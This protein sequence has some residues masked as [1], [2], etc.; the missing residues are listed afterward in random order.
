[1]HICPV[2]RDKHNNPRYLLNMKKITFILIA[3]ITGTTFA[4]DNAS[5]AVNAEIV[6]PITVSTTVPLEFGR[7][8][9]PSSATNVVVNTTAGGTRP[10]VAGVTLAGGAAATAASFNITAENT[11]TYDITVA[12][13]DLTPNTGA[14]ATMS[15][16]L[17]PDAT[18][19]TGT[20][21]A[22]TLFVGG[23]LVVNSGQLSDSYTGSAKVTVNYN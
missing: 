5:A 22:Q 12:A 10:D 2:N 21:S 7:I 17:Q 8:G 13:T 15:L 6:S 1:M 3:L 9:S 4:Q 18:S 14:G 16:T 19:G 23:T 20:G 11:Y